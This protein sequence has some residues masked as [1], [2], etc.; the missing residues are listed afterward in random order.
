[1]ALSTG[2][3]WRIWHV[4]S[5]PYVFF[6]AFSTCW[7]DLRLKLFCCRISSLVCTH[8]PS[9]ITTDSFAGLMG[10]T[11]PVQGLSDRCC[12]PRRQAKIDW[13]CSCPVAAAR[14]E[15]IRKEPISSS[16]MTR[17]LCAIANAAWL[18]TTAALISYPSCAKNRATT[19]WELCRPQRRCCLTTQVAAHTGEG[20]S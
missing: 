7:E 19:T 18:E 8:D 13:R 2:I 1:M 20:A 12:V 5:W 6:V 16:I 17:A 14:K 11:S 9:R 15:T 4:R 3:C 10:R